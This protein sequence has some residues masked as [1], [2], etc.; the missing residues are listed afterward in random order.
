MSDDYEARNSCPKCG[1]YYPPSSDEKKE[2]R[3]VY[4]QTWCLACGWIGP[5]DYLDSKRMKGWND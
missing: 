5:G 4:Y 2:L 3:T 1:G